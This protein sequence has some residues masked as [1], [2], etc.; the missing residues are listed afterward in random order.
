M[1][2]CEI[3]RRKALTGEGGRVDSEVASGERVMSLMK[4]K[5]LAQSSDFALEFDRRLFLAARTRAVRFDFSL[6]P[7]RQIL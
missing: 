1:N 7:R 4:N 6:V 5:S 3:L 2:L